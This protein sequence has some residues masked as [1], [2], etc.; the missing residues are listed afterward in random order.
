MEYVENVLQKVKDF[1]LKQGL[2]HEN[3]AFELGISQAAY[4]N[5]EN[6]STRL[7]VSRLIEISNILNRPVY[8]FF[9]TTP[10]K[11]YNQNVYDSSLGYQQDIENLY[12]DNK[13]VYQKLENSYKDMINLLKE[14]NDFLKKII[15]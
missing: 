1:R 4:S 12:Q 3:M 2:S 11:I 8:D 5:I 7:T 14:E 15:K 10:N 13:D 9:D 6:N